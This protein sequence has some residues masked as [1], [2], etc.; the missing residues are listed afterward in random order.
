MPLLDAHSLTPLPCAWPQNV[1]TFL[2][3]LIVTRVKSTNM[4]TFPASQAALFPFTQH[5]T[6]GPLSRELQEPW[7]YLLVVKGVTR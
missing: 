5:S 6:A 4:A 3:F 7:S 2:L 1:S